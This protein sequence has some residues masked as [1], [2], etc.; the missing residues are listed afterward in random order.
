MLKKTLDTFKNNFKVE[1]IAYFFLALLAFNFSNSLIAFVC[2]SLVANVILFI[3][4][5]KYNDTNLLTLALCTFPLLGFLVFLVSSNF[6]LDPSSNFDI[7]NF[8]FIFIGCLSIPLLGF[9][10]RIS[11]KVNIK[12]IIKIVYI[13]LAVYMV[14]NFLITI[15]NYGPFYTFIYKD[16]YFFDYGHLSR[17]SID[18][19]AYMLLGFKVSIVTVEFFSLF[20]SVLSSAILGLFFVS[21]KEDK[22]SFLVYLVCGCIGLLC[23]LLVFN[24]TLVISYAALL[25]GFVLTV[26]FAKKIIPFNKTTKIIIYSLLG[27]VAI[28]FIIFML[29]ALNV[30]PIASAIEN[31]AFLNKLF[32]NN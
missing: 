10:V 25:V 19:T 31:N 22:R 17:L 26:L 8:V 13:A 27:L 23:M 5:K 2:I 16:R 28:V 14:I 4:K 24:K 12:N 32:I 18:K 9:Q 6:Y 1:W 29:C 3:K 7:A 20:A 15:I 21:Y 30:Q 11:E